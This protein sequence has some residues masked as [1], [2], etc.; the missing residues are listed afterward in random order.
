M[1]S[2]SYLPRVSVTSVFDILVVAF[3]VYE[4]LKLIKGTRAIA[5]LVA[6][7]ILGLAF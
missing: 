4:F 1:P 6:V 2:L 7:V 3:L 5:M